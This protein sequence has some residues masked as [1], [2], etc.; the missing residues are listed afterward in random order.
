M[1]WLVTGGAGF[2]GINLVRHLLTRGDDVVS[3]DREPFDYPERRRIRE[4]RGDI[5]EREDVERA[6]AECDVVVHAAAALPLYPPDDIHT[7]DVDGTRTVLEASPAS[8]AWSTSRRP[9]STACP[10]TI[11]SSRAT[12]S[13]A[14]GRTAPR[15]SRQSACASAR[16]RAASAIAI[17]RPEVVRRARA[18][19]RVR[20]DVRVGARGP[21][22]PDPRARHEPLPA[23]RRRGPVHGDRARRHRRP[24]ARERHVQHRRRRVHHAARG[25]PGRARRRRPR[26]PHPLAAGRA[27]DRGPAR[28]RE[29][30]ALAAVSVDL[31]DGDRGLV[32]LHRPRPRRASAG[33]RATPTRTRWSAT[34]SGTANMQTSSAVRESRTAC[35]GSRGPSPWPS[36]RFPSTR[37][38][39]PPH[40]YR[41]YVFD[42]QARRR[43]RRT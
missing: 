1:R 24:R 42:H 22:L 33:S 17:L 25:L 5:R 9:P 14:S 8:G 20:A 34:T 37:D 10:I 2:L 12:S 31:R 3:L 11:R 35:P 15:R 4:I 16:A 30:E 38:K 13:P 18:A 6:V 21:R 19:R 29:G 41:T 39:R 36:S 27:R 28:A 26:P 23:A 43:R 40:G 32:R 7:I